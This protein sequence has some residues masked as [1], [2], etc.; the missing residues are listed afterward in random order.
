MPLALLLIVSMT[1]GGCDQSDAAKETAAARPVRAG[2][3]IL[4][5]VVRLQGKAPPPRPISNQPCHAGATP[6]VDESVVTDD[7]GHLQNVIVYLEDAPGAAPASPPP[8]VLDQVDCHYVPHVLALRTGQTLRVVNPD[9]AFHNVHG[10]CEKNPAFNFAEVSA[11][12]SKDMSFAAPERFTIR[13]DVHP[14]MRSVVQVFD[15]PW[16]AVTGKDG[17]FDIENVP[18]G[19]YTLVAWQERYGE[20]KMKV[21]AQ[22]AKTSRADLTFQTGL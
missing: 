15:H 18:P 17:S 10:M 9:P 5:G 8:A 16:F 14:W 19:E 1:G 20:V 6:I 7:A 22:D 12:Q 13:C 4:R 3:G 11:G 21:T 2:T